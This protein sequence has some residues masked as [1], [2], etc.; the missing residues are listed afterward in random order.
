MTNNPAIQKLTDQFVNALTFVI[1]ERAAQQA[2]AVL[3]DL[4]VMLARV[5]PDK[6][7]VKPQPHPRRTA[8]PQLCPVPGC[9]NRAAPVY[10]MVCAK[11]KDLPKVKIKAYRDARRAKKAR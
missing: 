4:G 1:E 2:A 11:H 6:A 5:V 10:G 9:K 8:P 3:N 7:P